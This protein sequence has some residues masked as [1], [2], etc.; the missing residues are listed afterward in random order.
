MLRRFA[1]AALALL[2]TTHQVV[3]QQMPPMGP[4]LV[5][6]T[7]MSLADVTDAQK[8]QIKTIV[9]Q[10]QPEI[11]AALAASDPMALRQVLRPVMQAILTTLTPAQREAVRTTVQHQLQGLD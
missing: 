7:I 3:A 4:R 11:Q 5:L 9:Q 10:Q 2:A 8:A 6:R 1:L